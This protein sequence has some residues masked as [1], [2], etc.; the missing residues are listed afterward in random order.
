MNWKEEFLFLEHENIKERAYYLW[1]Q[2][3]SPDNRDL[4]FWLEAEILY[5]KDEE[6]RE[7]RSQY[8]SKLISPIFFSK[9]VESDK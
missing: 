2:A 9:D 6:N 4:E 5:K 8:I 1:E 7:I 3:G